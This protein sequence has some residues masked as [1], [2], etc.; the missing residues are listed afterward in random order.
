MSFADYLSLRDEVPLGAWMFWMRRWGAEHRSLGYLRKTIW[1]KVK[2]RA[3][4]LEQ[5]LWDADEAKFSGK[6][7][8]GF[9]VSEIRARV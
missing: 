1:D 7:K 6:Q 4:I 5:I 2:R 9:I 8:V 3:D